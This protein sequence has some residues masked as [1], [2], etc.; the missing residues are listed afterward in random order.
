MFFFSSPCK[1]KL[2]VLF[3]RKIFVNVQKKKLNKLGET[4]GRIMNIIN[5]IA[6][7][8]HFRKAFYL[9][10]KLYSSAKLFFLRFSINIYNLECCLTIKTIWI[11]KRKNTIQNFRESSQTVRNNN[12]PT[13]SINKEVDKLLAVGKTQQTA[14]MWKCG[15][16][17]ILSDLTDPK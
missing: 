1:K 3:S 17:W 11:I 6:F 8:P 4:K 10:K 9:I 5:N 7:F 15:C 13:R 2:H 16:C 14:H 12:K